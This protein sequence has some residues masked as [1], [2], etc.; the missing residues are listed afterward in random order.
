M[1]S[2]VPEQDNKSR[3]RGTKCLKG[4]RT[5]VRT[6]CPPCLL[7]WRSLFLCCRCRLAE[8][9]GP[10]E[11]RAAAAGWAGHTGQ[12]ARRAGQ[13]PGRPG[14]TVSDPQNISNT[15]QSQCGNIQ[16][17]V[18]DL[19]V[20]KSLHVTLHPSCPACTPAW[21]GCHPD[22]RR[23]PPT[24]CQAVERSGPGPWR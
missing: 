8:D 16:A 12:Q 22:W 13:R 14:E 19:D 2:R 24:G 9:G 18:V 21:V 10:E 15:S 23:R 6:V 17:S 7:L 4:F 1:T 5:G 3:P 20:V 11:T